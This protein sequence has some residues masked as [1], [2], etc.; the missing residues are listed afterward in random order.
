MEQNGY[1]FGC[2]R[3]VGGRVI[4]RMGQDSPMAPQSPEHGLMILAPRHDADHPKPAAATSTASSGCSTTPPRKP[5][6]ARQFGERPIPVALLSSV[7]GADSLRGAQ[8][9][10]LY[11]VWSHDLDSVAD[12]LAGQ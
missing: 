9:T 7:L 8:A 11:L 4:R 5:V 3:F 12:W 10:G 2:Q 1:N 6:T